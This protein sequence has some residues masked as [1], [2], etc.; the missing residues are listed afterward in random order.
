MKH[1]ALIRTKLS[2]VYWTLLKITLHGVNSVSCGVYIVYKTG[3][4]VASQRTMTLC[5]IG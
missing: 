5:S 1:G 2:C 4:N 3:K